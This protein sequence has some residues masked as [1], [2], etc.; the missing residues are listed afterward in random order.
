MY[1]ECF[2]G[3]LKHLLLALR[4]LP[5]LLAL[6]KSRAACCDLCTCHCV[7]TLN[8]RYSN[9]S[10]PILLDSNKFVSNRNC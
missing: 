1:V 2:H 10:P 7:P 3:M 4:F 5:E 8:K 9:S 6:L